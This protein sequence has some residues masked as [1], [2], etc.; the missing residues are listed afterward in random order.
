LIIL[1]VTLGALSPIAIASLI[2]SA[3]T[4]LQGQLG[5][6]PVP[7]SQETL[8]TYIVRIPPGAAMRDN[9]IHY[10]PDNIAIP[11]GVTVV[12]F[13]DDPGQPHTVTSGK[14]GDNASGIFFNSGIIPCT[15]G[16]QH[17]SHLDSYHLIPPSVLKDDSLV[18]SLFSRED[19]PY[20]K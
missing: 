7:T 11:S 12:W 6:T 20:N 17:T 2:S 4:P 13:N 16:L 5:L 10:Y 8:P 14:F 19:M 3:N 1:L 15:A 18:D 9:S